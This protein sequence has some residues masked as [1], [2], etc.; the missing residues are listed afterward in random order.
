MKPKIKSILPFLILIFTAACSTTQ[1]SVETGD[2]N[3]PEIYIF[4]DVEKVDSNLVSDDSIKTKNENPPVLES[5]Q[6][7]DSMNVKQKI[8][9]YIVQVGA[10]STKQR[11]EKFVSENQSKINLKMNIGF[12]NQT[13]LF[14]VQL[15]FFDNRESAENYRNNIWQI[16]VFKDAFIITIEE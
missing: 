5:Q 14:V 12:N 11:A 2:Q 7:V 15:P 4:D 9:K 10:F 6:I 16:P 13:N 3:K 8:T 1:Q